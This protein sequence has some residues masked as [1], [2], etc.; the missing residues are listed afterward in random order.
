MT[1]FPAHQIAAFL[2]AAPDA[3]V[4]VDARGDI[5]FVNTQTEALFGYPRIELV[6]QPLEL[7]LPS[8]FRDSHV[9][10]RDGY[11][12]Q[13]QPRPMGQGLELFGLRKDGTEFAAEI[14]LSPVP[15]EQGLFISS[16]IRDI[17]DRKA[18][19]QT[20]TTARENALQENRAKSAFLA[21]AS[22][23]LRQPLQTLT[24]L[25]EVLSRAVPAESKAANVLAH[26]NVAL[27]SMA[28]L[29]NSLLDIS[30]LEAG[31]IKP[32][33][34]DCSVRPIFERLRSEFAAL[35]TAKGIELVVDDCDDTV[36]TDPRLLERIIQNFLANAIR[37]TETGSVRL[38]GVRASNAVRI[39]VADTGIGIAAEDIEKIFEEFY[40]A[41]YAGR[42]NREGVGLGLS[43]VRHLATLLDH[44]LEVESQVGKGSCFAVKVPRGRASPRQRKL[45]QIPSIAREPA[46]G[47]VL[48]IDDE[49]AVADAT[50]MLLEVVGFDVVVAGSA[51]QARELLV[52]RG[53][54]SPSVLLCDFRLSRGESGVDAV[55][56]VRADIGRTVP[57]I[58]VSGDTSSALQQALRGIDGCHVLSKPVNAD[59]LIELVGRLVASPAQD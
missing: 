29:L 31:A 24:L 15:T 40:Q 54:R 35:A 34:S 36:H 25:S 3:M 1:E 33:V 6:G 16:A 57:A 43:I 58:V 2:D 44:P 49:Q 12:S 4:I 59:E 50:A 21:A 19:E 18:V 48:V 28:D 55:R 38:H 37:Y 51:A 23:D 42:A 22:H 56:V 5:A 27:R 14:S 46:K 8:R 41:R 13:P 45:T 11:A 20:L 7:L 39:E 30:R 10:H 47:F 52:E 53:G 17:T 32:D 26:Q 9:A